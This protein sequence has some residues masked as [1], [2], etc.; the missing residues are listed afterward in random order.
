M[1]KK[2]IKQQISH[3]PV[4][5]V[6]ATK[7]INM[8]KKIITGVLFGVALLAGSFFLYSSKVRPIARSLKDYPTTITLP[9][10][11]DSTY[12]ANLEAL[13]FVN[14]ADV[15]TYHY[16]VA[17]QKW[18]RD[19]G[20]NFIGD[21][22]MT[23]FLEVNDFIMGESSRYIDK[24]PAA[25]GEL[26]IA[27]FKRIEKVVPHPLP[28]PD[29]MVWFNLT[30]EG[31]GEEIQ[32]MPPLPLIIYVVAGVNKFDTSGMEIKQGVLTAVA[33]PDPIA[34]MKVEH[35]WVELAAW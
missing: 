24:I 28:T 23:R 34:V 25:A 6:P 8:K 31:A 4:P 10:N 18:Q 30:H 27:N 17:R 2:Q 19:Y 21:N 11:V 5:E 22:E 29:Q 26:I 1:K 13:G 16:I 20:L 33:P 35:G 3:P 14:I 15:Q 9:A 7:P 12:V 32:I